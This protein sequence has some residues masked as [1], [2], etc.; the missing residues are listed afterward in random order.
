MRFVE[1]DARY[2]VEQR[3]GVGMARPRVEFLGGPDLTELAKVHDGDP[4]AYLVDDRQIVG[5]EEVGEPKLLAQLR[6]QVEHLRLDQDI[7]RGD[8]LVADEQPRLDRE[9]SRDRDA[10]ALSAR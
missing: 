2:G 8:S 5:D 4:V 7:E 10:L 3:S 6:E 9:R 1:V